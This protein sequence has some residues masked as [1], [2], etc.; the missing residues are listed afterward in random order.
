MVTVLKSICFFSQKYSTYYLEKWTVLELELETK[1]NA[2]AL[3]Q[4]R[5]RI[6]HGVFGAVSMI[7]LVISKMVLGKVLP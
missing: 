5:C 4:P 1:A 7:A 2:N 3:K 6:R